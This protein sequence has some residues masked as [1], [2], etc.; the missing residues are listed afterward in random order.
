MHNLYVIGNAKQMGG[1]EKAR[2]A[3]AMWKVYGYELPEPPNV[4]IE[5]VLTYLETYRLAADLSP[6][7]GASS[8]Y[9]E[10]ANGGD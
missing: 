6:V 7:R 1:L 8:T 4:M 2:F 10:Y 3:A 9:P 5:R